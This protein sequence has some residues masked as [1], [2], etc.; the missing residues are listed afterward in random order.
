LEIQNKSTC[1]LEPNLGIQE[2]LSYKV[3]GLGW[4][5]NEFKVEQENRIAKILTNITSYVTNYMN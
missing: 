3:A 2:S 5:T 1:P 4:T